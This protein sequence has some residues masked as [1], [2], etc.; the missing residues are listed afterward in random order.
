MLFSGYSLSHRRKSINL[1]T[2]VKQ[3][4]II[5][6]K[7]STVNLTASSASDRA[8]INLLNATDDILLH[9][10]LRRDCDII[11]FNTKPKNGSWG[12]E[13]NVHYLRNLFLHPSDGSSITIIDLGDRFQ[14]LFDF[15]TIHFFK[16]RLG[17]N[18]AKLAYFLDPDSGS[19][20]AD[21]LDVTVH[22]DY[23]QMGR[24]I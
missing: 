19:P 11:A 4:G 20:L 17:G 18:V 22:T 9:I 6:I 24:S 13:N 1:A 7:S 5:V 12:S 14:V 23:S 21:I 3:D 8:Q 15:K 10:G 2:E 16:K